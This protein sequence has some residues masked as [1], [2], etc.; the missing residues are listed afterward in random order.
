MKI[1]YNNCFGGFSLSDAGM[2]RYAKIKGITLYSEKDRFGFL[3]YW[4]APKSERVGLLS[5]KD[6]DNATVKER[7]ASNEACNKLQLSTRDFDRTD[8]ILVQVVEELGDEANGSCASLAI[9]DVPTGKKYRI[10][11]YA[12]NE[13]V[14]MIDDH[15]WQTAS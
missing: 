13:S 8:S 6:W 10:D 7:I 15:D 11:E 12:G 2:R 9:K 4:I 14:M 3:T 1:V 5:D